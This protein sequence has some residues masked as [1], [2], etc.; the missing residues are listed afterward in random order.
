FYVEIS[1]SGNGAH[2]WFFF[3]TPISSIEAR[4]FG[5]ALLTYSM[6]KRHEIT[7]KSYDRLFPNQD[8]MPNGGFGNLIALPLQ[9]SA[10]TNGNSI[11][12]DDNFLP[13]QD[14]WLFFTE[15]KKITEDLLKFYT[16]K[17]CKGN[18]LGNLKPDEEEN[19]KPIQSAV[20]KI[21]K[22]NFP[23]KIEIVKRNMLYIKKTDISEKGLNYIKRFAAF[24]N[25]EFYK[26]QMMRLPTFN[27]PRIISCSEETE[28]YL[29]LPRG[30]ESDLKELCESLNINLEIVENTNAGKN[31]NVEFIGNLRDEQPKALEKLLTNDNGVL[32]GTTAFGKTVAA[33]K[34]I[35]ERKVN[36]IILVDKVN[37]VNQWKKRLEEFLKINDNIFNENMQNSKKKKSNKGIIGQIGASKNNLNGI[38]DIGVMQS[39]YRN[40]EVNECINNY[41]MIIVDECHHVSAFSFEQILK[42][43]NAKYVYGLTATPTR[44]DGHHPIIYMQCG[45]IRYR[46]DAKKQA[47]KR[48]FQHY[49]IPRFTD[50]RPSLDKDMEIAAINEIYAEIT[51]SE[52]RNELIVN[53][54]I[55]SYKSGRNCLILSERTHHVEL[56]FQKLKESIPDV[57]ALTGGMG[58]K[59]SRELF[60]RI[61]LLPSDKQLC[62]VATGK[63]IGEGFDE[64]RLDTLFLTMPIS[65]KG[66][67]QQ[68]AG[69][70]HRLYENKKDV[71]VYD[72]VDI[73]I[74]MLEKMYNK[75]LSGYAS[76]GYKVK[77]DEINSE[78]INIIY[79]NNNFLPVYNSDIINSKKE[80]LIVSPFL[81]KRRTLIM[82]ESLKMARDNN[83]NIIVITRP[84]E[85][86]NDKKKEIYNL[87]E[88][89]GL[90]EEN[91]IKIIFKSKIHQKFAIIDK[92][93]VWFGSI[94]LL[95]FGNSCESIMRLLSSNI[96]NELV[97]SIYPIIESNN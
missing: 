27:K 94:N 25:P 2:A 87:K 15:I 8:F 14:Q 90:L 20:T 51:T 41:G 93:I 6:N 5:T 73:H 17:M 13:Y 95:S 56:I 84:L 9:K 85:D 67:L 47:I 68:Y 43:S 77:S 44:K 60:S 89:Y 71:I 66:T 78:S 28:K 11:F 31:I 80:I 45:D 58:I 48:P 42:K 91:G 88:T 52:I 69:R 97:K 75:R 38:I 83:V 65:W 32:C 39:L 64:P 4:K 12:I 63:F 10:R 86:F 16:L 59:E 24:K 40:G 30:C 7:F 92:K 21:G 36:T 18:E 79:D 35:A 1:R 54:I 61:S 50:F 23:R 33:I 72:Y 3:D 53:D 29:C 76:I 74:R 96:A 22:E 62:I 57:I 55:K 37:L 34:L 46:D 81:S 19:E 82:L 70:L 49:I 26:A